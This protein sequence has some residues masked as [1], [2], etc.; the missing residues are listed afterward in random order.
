MLDF[1]SDEYEDS[2]KLERIKT[3]VLKPSKD[4][5]ER[6]ARINKYLSWVS[7]IIVNKLQLSLYVIHKNQTNKHKLQ[8]SFYVIHTKN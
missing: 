7:E 2:K 8:L 6:K 3:S 5:A 1:F 4:R